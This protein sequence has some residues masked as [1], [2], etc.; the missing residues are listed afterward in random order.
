MPI[1]TI[2]KY[3]DI[4]QEQRCIPVI[5]PLLYYMFRFFRRKNKRTKNVFRKYRKYV[6]SLN[7][8]QSK[9]VLH[10]KYEK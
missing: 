4:Y 10:Q 3:H 5:T 9:R 1:L 7:T 8:C 2:W 6:Y